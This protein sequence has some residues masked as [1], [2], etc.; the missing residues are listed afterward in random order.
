MSRTDLEKPG[1]KRR[2][3]QSRECALVGAVMLAGGLVAL[4][5]NAAIRDNL[6]LDAGLFVVTTMPGCV[7]LAI[8]G[9]L[10]ALTAARLITTGPPQ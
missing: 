3:D 10:Y 1:M 2:I 9:I 5:L 4:T 7:M 6:T 8:A